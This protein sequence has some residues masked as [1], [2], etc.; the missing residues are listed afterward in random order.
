[1]VPQRELA[2][3]V[4]ANH[5]AMQSCNLVELA[6]LVSAE[7]PGLLR[8]EGRFSAAGIDAYWTASKCRLDRWSRR[9]KH[10]RHGDGASSNSSILA[11]KS[12]LATCTEILT[13]EIL[14]RV[15]TAA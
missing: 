3:G 10:A 6:A 9:L 2:S 4:L 5:S 12:C 7:T 14:T 8:I 15:W 11:E 1:M 13:S